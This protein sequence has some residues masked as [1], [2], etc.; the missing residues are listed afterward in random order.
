MRKHDV[1]PDA[2]LASPLPRGL[3][4]AEIVAKKLDATAIADAALSPGFDLEKLAA[5]LAARRDAGS[6]MLV[7]H[8]P[9]LS[10]IIR[11][12]TGGIVKLPKGA[13]AC[14]ESTETAEKNSARLLW[15]LTQKLCK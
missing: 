7:G 13:V 15:L 9:D 8:E 12:L 1:A 6:I 2:L 5:I 4:T 11:Q 14:L 10:K 3:E